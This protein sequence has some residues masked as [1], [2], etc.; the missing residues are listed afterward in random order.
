M[1]RAIS[2]KVVVDNVH[3]EYALGF[4]RRGN[5]S[6]FQDSLLQALVPEVVVGSVKDA[7]DRSGMEVEPKVA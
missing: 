3:L 7:F 2:L 4:F 6:L 1:V 5:S